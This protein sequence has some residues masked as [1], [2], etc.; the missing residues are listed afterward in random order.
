M[1]QSSNPGPAAV[2]GV[3]HLGRIRPLQMRFR[4]HVRWAGRRIADH[5]CL[6]H[7]AAE[8]FVRVYDRIGYGSRLF[9]RSDASRRRVRCAVAAVI[10]PPV[11]R[12][13]GRAAGVPEG[14]GGLL[15]RRARPSHV[16]PESRRFRVAV[17]IFRAPRPGRVPGGPR[18]P[19]RAVGPRAP[20]PED[21]HS[22]YRRGIR[23]V[24][25]RRVVPRRR[26]R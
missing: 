9:G 2:S 6:S 20:G 23:R 22:R 5:C 12:L 7:C 21:D 25:R 10:G 19:G 14:S 18:R 16:E 11:A 26:G 1:S 4:R 13:P 3:V 17:S 24:V 8:V 15:R